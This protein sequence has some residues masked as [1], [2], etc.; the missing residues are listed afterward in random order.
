MISGDFLLRSGDREKSSK[1]GVSRRNRESWLVCAFQRI[2]EKI[3]LQCELS[4]LSG[5]LADLHQC[6]VNCVTCRRTAKTKRRNV[7]HAQTAH[8]PQSYKTQIY[9]KERP[10]CSITTATHKFEITG[11]NTSCDLNFV[12]TSFCK[13]TVVQLRGVQSQFLLCSYFKLSP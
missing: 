5:K 8:K 13:I 6:P 1:S 10:W 11:P 9:Y 12:A 4:P 3:D 2:S 7:L